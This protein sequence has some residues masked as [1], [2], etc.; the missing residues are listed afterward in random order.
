MNQSTNNKLTLQFDSE[1]YPSADEVAEWTV[2][3]GGGVDLPFSAATHPHAST[4]W[5]WNF[6]H[7]PGWSDGDHVLVA[8][9]TKEVQNRVGQ[10][11]FRATDPSLAGNIHSIS[12][13][14]WS[15]SEFIS[16]SSFNVQGHT[17][18]LQLLEVI[19]GGTDDED[20][21]WIT[22]TF[23]TPN[24]AISW[25]AY[26]EGEI[27]QF[28]TLFIRW[29]DNLNKRPSTYTLP[30]KTAATEGGIQRSGR[31]VTFVWVRTNKEF[32]RRGL[33]WAKQAEIYAEM[34]AP[35]RPADGQEHDHNNQPEQQPAR[36]P[37]ISTACTPR[38]RP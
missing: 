1:A 19:R 23:R 4:P 24:E 22:A 28:H 29:Y 21:I 16:D 33:A 31:N 5:T 8:I 14:R 17:F 15:G 7:I 36:T 27:E 26:W 35:P 18:S 20:P 9:R 13:N 25:K 32:E 10:I 30:L 3:L 34:L 11:I 6:D 12:K 38:A 37:T 2:T